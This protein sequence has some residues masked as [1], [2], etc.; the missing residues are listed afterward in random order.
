M[1]TE[2]KKHMQYKQY[3][4][5]QLRRQDKY[6]DESATHMILNVVTWVENNNWE[7][8]PLIHSYSK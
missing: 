3:K 8:K 5:V 2:R 7:W 4:I 6:F 1:L